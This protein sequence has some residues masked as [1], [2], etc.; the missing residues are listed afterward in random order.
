MCILRLLRKHNF[1]F[2]VESWVDAVSRVADGRFERTVP[3]K[4]Y[5][6]EAHFMLVAQ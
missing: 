4:A 5:P 2:F 6:G 3:D 1:N